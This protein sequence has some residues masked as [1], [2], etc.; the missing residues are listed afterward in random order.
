MLLTKYAHVLEGFSYISMDGARPIHHVV[1]H[2]LA[3]FSSVPWFKS[4]TLQNLESL[5]S[6]KDIGQLFLIDLLAC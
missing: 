1:L 6:C 4:P 2:C 3:L 5:E